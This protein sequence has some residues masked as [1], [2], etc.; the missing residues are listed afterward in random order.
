MATIK[1]RYVL[2]IDTKGATEN[3]NRTK[4]KLGGLGAAIGRLGPLAVAAGAALGGMAVVNGITET[5]SAM[6][7]MVK[8]AREVGAAASEADFSRYQEVREFFNQGGV[9]ARTFERGLRQLQAQMTKAATDGTGALKNSFEELRPVLTDATG[10]LLQPQDAVIALQAAL[11]EGKISQEAFNDAMTAVGATAGPK[12]AAAMGVA[13]DSAADLE[14]AIAGVA[15]NAASFSLDA[16]GNAED[17][18]DR[19]QDLSNNFTK[20]KQDLVSALL[21]ALTTLAEGALK[22]IPPLIENVGAGLQRL[23][24][25]F[26][27]AGAVIAAFQPVAE[28]LWGILG[29]LFDIIMPIVDIALTGLVK[30][31]ELVAAALEFVLNGVNSF[32]EGLGN[33]KQLVADTTDAIIGGFKDMGE[34]ILGFVTAPLEGIKGAFK[35]LWG[36]LWGGSVAKDI[37]ETTKEGFDDMGT[38]MVGSVE[39]V[40]ANIRNAFSNIYNS[41]RSGLSSAVNTASTGFKNAIGGIGDWFSDTFGEAGDTAEETRKQLEGALSGGIDATQLQGSADAMNQLVESIEASAPG[42]ESYNN[43]S[44]LLNATLTEQ[45]ETLEALLENYTNLAE[46]KTTLNELQSDELDSLTQIRDSVDAIN[47]LL[48]DEVGKLDS[49]NESLTLLNTTMAENERITKSFYDVLATTFDTM[50]KSIE[51]DTAKASSSNAFNSAL[52]T[53]GDFLSNYAD[54]LQGLIT[55]TTG[56]TT[57]TNNLAT[58]FQQMGNTADAAARS[59]T[60][61]IGQIEKQINLA[62]QANNISLPN[63][64]NNTNNNPF[65]IFGAFAD[66]GF[67]PSGKIGLVGENGPELITG[68]GRITPMEDVNF[69][70]GTTNVTYNI[71][72]VDAR[73][74]QQLVAEDPGFI[75]AVA[76]YGGRQVPRRRK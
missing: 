34:K 28:A 30:G 60:Q 45:G 19:L 4:G 29:Q 36:Y 20:V 61:A 71:S 49:K 66:G 22:I 76:E 70:G 52:E 58:A 23:S 24:P 65:N 40:A 74:F 3:I 48:G 62:N 51:L 57:D 14:N 50:S 72:A 9:D 75:H 25:V 27:A 15:E 7:D 6:D 53:S 38:S 42:M 13:G 10:A 47:G 35:D 43:T 33:V 12:F 44:D 46:V 68:P 21:P 32:F 16:A 5:A 54:A 31:F 56:L 55:W 26:E 18:N 59:A 17:F 37:V 73:S 64:N 41:I 11:N 69:G 8:A 1:D 39:G 2:E 67:L 63:F